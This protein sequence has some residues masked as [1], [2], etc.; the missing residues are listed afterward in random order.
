MYTDQAIKDMLNEISAKFDSGELT[1]E[2]AAAQLTELF[3]NDVSASYTRANHL[4]KW[5]SFDLCP[6]ADKVRFRDELVTPAEKAAILQGEDCNYISIFNTQ[7][8]HM[9]QSD[10]MSA[11]LQQ[12]FPDADERSLFLYG[13]ANPTT[14]VEPPEDLTDEKNI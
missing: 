6:E 4:S 5:L 9:W 7:A 3:E 13:E 12:I 1:A 14:F 2:Q 8:G 11:L 10:E